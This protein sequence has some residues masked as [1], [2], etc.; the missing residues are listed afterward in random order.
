MMGER[1][2]ANGNVTIPFYIT[3]PLHYAFRKPMYGLTYIMEK[4]AYAVQEINL[5]I[6][7]T[8]FHKDPLDDPLKGAYGVLTRAYNVLEAGQI[9]ANISIN[10]TGLEWM[11]RFVE[12]VM[13]YA[14]EIVLELDGDIE[15]Y[16][17]LPPLPEPAPPPEPEFTWPQMPELKDLVHQAEEVEKMFQEAEEKAQHVEEHVKNFGHHHHGPENGPGTGPPPADDSEVADGPDSVRLSKPAQNH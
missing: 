3:K 16:P 2:Y 13:E 10:R 15:R 12:P 17:A 14:R 11:P 4:S 9:F 8:H 5:K 1:A 6:R 7:P